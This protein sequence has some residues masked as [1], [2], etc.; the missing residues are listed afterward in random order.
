ML[1]DTKIF[2]SHSKEHI[3]IEVKIEIV[4][5]ADCSL[6]GGFVVHSLRWS[7]DASA[8]QQQ[9]NLDTSRLRPQ[10]LI[11]GCFTHTHTHTHTQTFHV[12]VFI[13]L[14]QFVSVQAAITFPPLASERRS[15]LEAADVR[16][17]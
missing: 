13:G 16:A 8:S 6:C 2:S 3:Y 4:E 17:I 14:Q 11:T 9:L 12:W 10:P 15:S 1:T 7:H 5:I